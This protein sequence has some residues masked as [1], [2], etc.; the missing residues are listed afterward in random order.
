M[1]T[2]R[3]AATTSA[4]V[5]SMRPKR[6]L[7]LIAS[8]AAEQR[9]MRGD[10]QRD[11]AMLGDAGVIQQAPIFGRFK[12]PASLDSVGPHHRRGSIGFLGPHR[13]SCAGP[14]ARRPG[15]SATRTRLAPTHQRPP[16]AAG[17]ASRAR[18]YAPAAGR[19]CPLGSVRNLGF[20]HRNAGVGKSMAYAVHMLCAKVIGCFGSTAARGRGCRRQRTAHLG[21]TRSARRRAPDRPAC[22]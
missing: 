4:A 19:D 7:Y 13:P 6:A 1:C 18:L 3:L 8:P 5:A 15:R 14:G 20:T 17:R 11:W 12:K 21:P 9:C 16:Y 22:A 2:V 10:A